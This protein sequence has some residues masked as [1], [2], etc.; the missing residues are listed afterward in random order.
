MTPTQPS[1]AAEAALNNLT[2]VLCD[3]EGLCCISGSDADR[4]VVDV[5][6]ATLR[7]ELTRPEDRLTLAEY[8][9]KVA[10]LAEAE[11]ASSCAL[12]KDY[13]EC[14]GD[15]LSCPENEGNGC[16]G[17]TQDVA[18][19]SYEDV[20]RALA[21][22][23]EVGPGSCER[24]MR[25]ALE[26]FVASRV[27]VALPAEPVAWMIGGDL[28]KTEEAAK[29][30]R[31][32]LETFDQIYP[33]YP[34]D[35]KPDRW[36]D[37]AMPP[38]I[39]RRLAP[40]LTNG[41]ALH[42]LTINLVVRFSRALAAKLAAAEVKYG[43]SDGWQSPGWMDECREK[44]TEHVAKGDP[45]DVAAYCAFLWHHGESTASPAPKQRDAKP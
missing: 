25:A 41:A 4:E 33:L 17:R 28:F 45:R 27:S 5:A 31:R 44:L 34:A 12:R 29:S 32:H 38:D 39:E 11:C 6:L 9:E 15:E 23:R 42:P 13:P 3:P 10:T 8:T 37:A 22:S 21:V 18:A 20:N 43:Y 36:A 1:R 24:G 26:D 19:V 40:W 35:P 2:A 14:S 16:C 7:A 30:Q